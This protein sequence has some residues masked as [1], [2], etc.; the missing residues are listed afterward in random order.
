MAL[1]DQS[2]K[3]GASLWALV[4]RLQSQHWPPGVSVVLV[5]CQL[6]PHSHPHLPTPAVSCSKPPGMPE[7]ASDK[8][9]GRRESQPQFLTL[10]MLVQ[11]WKVAKKQ[12]W[13]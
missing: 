6:L 13:R 10:R 8:V 9:G 4:L 3:T 11:P 12:R 1:D 5:T 2:L 7:R